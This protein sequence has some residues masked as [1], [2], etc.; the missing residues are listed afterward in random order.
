VLLVLLLGRNLVGARSQLAQQHPD[1]LVGDVV[2]SEDSWHQQILALDVT[3]PDAAEHLASVYRFLAQEGFSY[4]KLDFLLAGAL[5]GRRHQDASPLDAYRLGLQV[6]RDAVGEEAL[7]L[8]CG[9]PLLPSIGLVDAMRVSPDVSAQ[10][11]PE[12]GDM[13]Q[14]GMRSAMAA[15]RARTWQHGRFWVNDPDCL[16]ARPEVAHRD[17][18]AEHVAASGGLAISSDPLAALDEH[19]LDLTR[20]VLRPAEPRPVPWAPEVL[21]PEPTRR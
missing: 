10:L 19:G 15:G 16:L 13:C 12:L 8:G 2:V 1:W 9:A 20:R 14:P 5:P 6:V 21:V 4:Y 3:H 7:L 17:A 18:W 11:E